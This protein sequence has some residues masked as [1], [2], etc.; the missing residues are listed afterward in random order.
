[1]QINTPNSKSIL[2]KKRVGDFG[3]LPDREE[4]LL[5]IG[6]LIVTEKSYRLRRI[7][8]F[9]KRDT[10]VQILE[11]LHT[12]TSTLTERAATLLL[13]MLA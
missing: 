3:R 4:D 12:T 1:M 13:M 10:L 11:S 8:F 6:E 5:S 2:A 9:K 7:V